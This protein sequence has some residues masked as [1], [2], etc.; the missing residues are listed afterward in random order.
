MKCSREEVRGAESDL[1]EIWGIGR[2]F[3]VWRKKNVMEETRVSKS[4][5][6]VSDRQPLSWHSV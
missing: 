2:I 6:T 4:L 1:E 3:K 5:S